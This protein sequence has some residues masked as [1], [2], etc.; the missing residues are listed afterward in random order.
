M[1]KDFP[2]ILERD[3]IKI[4]SEETRGAHEELLILSAG[5]EETRLANKLLISPPGFKCLSFIIEPG[6]LGLVCLILLDIIC[7][8]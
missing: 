3:S 1:S 6:F 5:A 4:N 7:E 8:C 2:L